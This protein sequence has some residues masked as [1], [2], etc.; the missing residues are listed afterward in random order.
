VPL[1]DR[2][3]PAEQATDAFDPLEGAGKL[4]KVLIDF[5]A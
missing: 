1:V 4:G 2:I 3:F 5:G